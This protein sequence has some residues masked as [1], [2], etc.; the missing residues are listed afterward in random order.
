[1]RLGMAVALGVLS[2]GAALVGCSAPATVASSEPQT[3]SPSPTPAQK[4]YPLRITLLVHPLPGAAD[5]TRCVVST[6]PPY[7]DFWTTLHSEVEWRV[8]NNACPGLKA[9]ITAVDA[10]QIRLVE[11]GEGAKARIVGAL[12]EAAI[13]QGSATPYPDAGGQPTVKYNVHLDGSRPAFTEDPVIV[14]W[15]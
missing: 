6:I 14:I 10:N 5:A 4:K 15:P 2:G 3:A 11:S 13:R 7:A 12:N 1:V 8:V 9:R